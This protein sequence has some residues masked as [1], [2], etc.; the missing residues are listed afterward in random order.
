MSYNRY[1]KLYRDGEIKKMPGITINK[2]NTDYYVS[3]NK[4]ISRL[5]KISYDYY[6]DSGYDWLILMANNDIEGLEF[7][8]PDGFILRVPY[9]L[10]DVI[11]EFNNKIDSY[12]L[13]YGVE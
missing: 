13:L 8:I 5:D 10:E 9:P 3:F 11:S 1:S 6:G 7:N 4:A 2:R 12:N